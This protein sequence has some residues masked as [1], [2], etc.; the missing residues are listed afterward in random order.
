M[1]IG[2]SGKA[3]PDRALEV[4][5]ELTNALIRDYNE[6]KCKGLD[7]EASDIKG[8]FGLYLHGCYR[9]FYQND[10]NGIADADRFKKCKRMPDDVE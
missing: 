5:E 1:G 6:C 10:D 2:G 4:I 8:N 3:D 7:A 9:P